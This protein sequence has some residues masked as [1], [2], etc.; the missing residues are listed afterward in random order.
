[1]SSVAIFPDGNWL[2]H[3]AYHAVGKTSNIPHVKVPLL[4][5]DWIFSYLI[6]WNSSNC[7]VCFDGDNVFR[8]VVY[9]EYKAKRNSNRSEYEASGDPV[10]DLLPSVINCLNLCG[11]YVQ[12]DSEY[13][14]DDLI[15]SGSKKWVALNPSNK[16]I[17]IA[18]DKDSLQN[19][20]DKILCFTPGVKDSL[21]DITW[22]EAKVKEVKGM[23]PKEYLRYQILTGDKIDNIP[24]L[25]SPRRARQ[26]VTSFKTL[27]DYF[28]TD[29]GASFY[30]ANKGALIL[31]KLLVTMVADSWKTNFSKI[32]VTDS[33][34][35]NDQLI[36]T[37]GRI[38]SGLS[39]Y[40]A[41]GN[42]KTS[43]FGN[44]R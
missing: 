6:K 21:S 10:Y 28:D 35:N 27:K 2:L 16:A 8:Y 34:I 15:S 25:M 9:S 44:Q 5:T 14:A 29:E 37:F 13:E 23:Y 19:I 24:S 17:I 39:S 36:E 42:R 12:Q 1:M 40:R 7:A 4:I 33:K 41:I 22:T 11:V 30:K 43:I 18:K 31:N 26:V 3:R 32:K 38:P 20:T